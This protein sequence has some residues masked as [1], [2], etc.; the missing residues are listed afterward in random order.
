M[1]DLPR[2]LCSDAPR[3]AKVELPVFGDASEKGF[4]A[5][6]YTRYVFPDERIEVAFVMAKTR[7]APLGQ[8]SIPR[9]ELQ[10]ALLA[11][12]LAEIIKKELTLRTSKTVFWSDS[13]TVLLYILNESRRFHTFVASRVAEI[14]D[15]TQP[16]QW[17]FVP[18]R[19]NP[20]TL[21]AVGISY[22]KQE[23][24]HCEQPSAFPSSMRE[25][26]TPHVIHL[27]SISFSN[28]FFALSVCSKECKFLAKI[29]DK[30]T[31]HTFVEVLYISN[32]WSTYK[33]QI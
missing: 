33:A 9:L 31:I 24:N 20:A 27:R 21:R 30:R 6:C 26:V 11:V 8:P 23:K 13:K 15:S 16:A 29:A 12:I 7:V 5:V 10:A 3:D 14:Q 22:A 17:R 2:R 1:F 25:F 32:L 19:L 4:G 28:L 18:G